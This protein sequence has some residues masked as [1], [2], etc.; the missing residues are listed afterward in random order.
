MKTAYFILG[1]HRSGTSALG[2]VL[3]IMGLEFGSDLMKADEG[4]PKGYFENNFVYRLN[5][6]ILNENSSIWSD[7]SFSIDKISFDEK[8]NYIEEAKNIIRK[9]FR[10]SEKFV[11]KDPRISLLFPIWEQACLDLN[12]NI[13]VI[14]PFRNP[15]E[16]ALSLK[17]R[18]GFSMEKS[19]LLWTHYFLSAEYLSRNYDRLF[20][21]FNRLLEDK[22]KSISLLS[23]FVDL[24]IEE[25][26]GRI[27]EFLD[28]NIKNNNVPLENFTKQTP[29]FLQNLIELLK[30]SK[31]DDLDKIDG[32]RND[33]NFSLEIFQHDELTKVLKATPD[34]NKKL[35]LLEKI[36]DISLVDEGYY[37]NRY[38]D[39]KKY[40]GPLSEHYFRYGK[41]E[42][43]HPNEY[44]E[45]YKINTK[46]ETAR[47][48]KLY[49][50]TVKLNNTLK[51]KEEKFQELKVCINT[52]EIE[53]Q[54]IK[55][56]LENERE[57]N[58]KLE[59]EEKN[60][61][62]LINRLEIEKEQ[63][64]NE[65]E[66]EREVN[67]KLEREKKNK[68]ALI[69]R[70]EIE[71]EQIS[72][73]LDETKEVN[74]KLEIEQKKKVELINKLQ[75]EKQKITNELKNKLAKITLLNKNLDEIVE[76]LVSVK[77]SKCWIYT[78]PIR[79]LEK[80]LKG[81]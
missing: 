43:R 18:N 8:K 65:L 40:N 6:K 20:L 56:E 13:K 17:K 74:H 32:I 61:V 9:E 22:K 14:I 10:Y 24:N 35:N 26:D 49:L 59:R 3:N 11:I 63:T 76:D 47:D 23:N 75:N 7:Y 57:V 77:E 34:K 69:N 2:G 53:K 30:E 55:D 70:L 45:Y 33:F 67:R 60:K 68:V 15:K 50:Q 19:F 1:M 36:K 62:A 80:V 29:F 38:P 52:L 73:A 39:L 46:K 42:G 71:K 25:K 12:I 37:L 27:D 81:K 5:K 72:N 79:S 31:F 4:N 41:K 51:D 58:R 21:S 54:T 78:K 44:C 28:T 16:V 66:N 48:E 64:N